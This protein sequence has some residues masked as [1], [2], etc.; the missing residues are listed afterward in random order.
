LIPQPRNQPSTRARAAGT[1]RRSARRRSGLPDRRPES[2]EDRFKGPFASALL[3]IL[4]ALNAGES[5]L[6]DTATQDGF[7]GFLAAG[8]GG[9]SLIVVLVLF[10]AIFAGADIKATPL[11]QRG[12]VRLATALG[13]E[14]VGREWDHGADGEPGPRF[15]PRRAAPAARIVEGPLHLTPPA[16]GPLAKP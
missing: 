2:Y 12:G 9:M 13:V 4:G 6:V 5:S 8:A 1:A 11:E 15:A 14:R 10:G 7:I 16:P 3:A